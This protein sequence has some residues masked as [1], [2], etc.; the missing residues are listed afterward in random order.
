MPVIKENKVLEEEEEDENVIRRRGKKKKK[1]Q[2]DSSRGPSA[3]ETIDPETQI[4]T[5][6]PDSH[7]PSARPSLVPTNIRGEEQI[8]LESRTSLDINSYLDTE[9]LKLL[10][11][12]LDEEVVD[13]EFDHK[14]RFMC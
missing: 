2:R 6:G 7:N 12:E 4:E 3:F 5:L 1:K 9:I 8:K 11:R 13:N 10:R 14:V